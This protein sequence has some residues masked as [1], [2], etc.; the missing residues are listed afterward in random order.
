MR[1]T[2][3]TS[4]GLLGLFKPEETG[5]AFQLQPANQSDM[6]GGVFVQKRTLEVVYDAV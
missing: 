5:R 4:D 2:P 3:L 1:P 6:R